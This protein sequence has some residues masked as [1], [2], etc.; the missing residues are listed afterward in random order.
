MHL[1]MLSPRE[2]EKGRATHGNLIVRP[3]PWVGM[4]NVHNVPRVGKFEAIWGAQLT[5]ACL[6]VGNFNT[7]NL[8]CCPGGT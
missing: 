2:G 7:F 1:S 3:V 8:I 4:L 5:F 6:R